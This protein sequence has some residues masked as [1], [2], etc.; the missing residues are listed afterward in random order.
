MPQ[1]SS[2]KIITLNIEGDKHLDQI[3]PFLEQENPDVICLQEVFKIDVEKFKTALNM[4]AFFTPLVNI[5]H[6]TRYNIAP[7]GIWG[8]LILTKNQ[9]IENKFKYYVQH[10]GDNIP[11]FID[12]KPNSLNRAISWVEIRK[13]DVE[14]TVATTHFTWSNKGKLS[15]EQENNFAALEKI[16]PE[17]GECILCGDF[18]SPRGEGSF[19][20]FTK[21]FKDNV[22]AEIT[23]TIDNEIHVSPD[24]I[25]LVVDNIFSTKDY[26]VSDVKVVDGLSDHLAVVGVVRK[27]KK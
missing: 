22:P 6:R 12:E 20:L 15:K 1:H 25:Q 26:Q 5:T 14:Y 2:L 7:N 9:I 23:T 21:Y 11:V 16:F 18:N 4:E 3:I 19:S 10:D 24:N 17:I 8:L 13:N 27:V